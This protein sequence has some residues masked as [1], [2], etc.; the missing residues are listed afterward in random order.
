MATCPGCQAQLSAADVRAGQCTACGRALDDPGKQTD[1]HLFAATIQFD[2]GILPDDAD[3]ASAGSPPAAGSGSAAPIGPA[4]AT[5]AASESKVREML[6]AGAASVPSAPANPP[7]APPGPA[8]EEAGGGTV[9]ER[10]L[11]QTIDS[12]V[13][14]ADSDSTR[15]SDFS[16]GS[17]GGSGVISAGPGNDSQTLDSAVGGSNSFDLG[18]AGLGASSAEL[19]RKTASDR[20]RHLAQTFD[21]SVV[22]S[23][24]GPVLA[25]AWGQEVPQEGDGRMTIKGRA[26]RGSRADQ[27]LVVNARSLQPVD[28]P[29]RG[30]ADYELLEVLGEGGMGVV[31]AARQASIDRT[32]AV[33][34]LKPGLAR[35]RDLE[36]K[37]LSEAVVTGDLDH[38]NIVPMYDL[39]K[40]D[41]GALFYA[42]KRVQGTPWSKAIG[43]KSLH[44]NLEILMK[45]ADAVAFAHARGVVHRD[46]KPENVMLGEFGEVLV[47]DWGLAY[48]TPEFRKSGSITQTQSMGGSPAYMAPEMALGPLDRISPL[49]DVYLLGAILYEIITGKPPHRGQNVSKCLAAAARNEIQPTDKS[50]EL[51]EIALRAM[52]TEPAARY[53]TVLAFQQALRDYL[54]HA[55]SIVLTGRA[56]QDLA[57]AT[58]SQ[59]Y[60]TFARALFAFEEALALWEGNAR[61]RTSAA[62]ARLAY[63]TCAL[64]K[65]DY[66]LAAG[67]LTADDPAHAPLAAR[68]DEARRERDARQRRLRQAKRVVVALGVAVVVILAVA[69]FGIRS[70][71]DRALVAESQARDDRDRAVV[72]E[73]QAK[74]DRDRAV[75]AE[76]QAKQDRDRAIAAGEQAKEERDRAVAAEAVAERERDRAEEAHEAEEYQAYIARIGLASAKI[77]E[78]AFDGAA[79]L[80]DDCPPELRHWEWGRLNYLCGQSRLSLDAGAPASAVAW[81]PDG[82]RAA[83]AAWNGEVRV[84]QWPAGTL[85]RTIPFGGT[86]VHAVAWSPDGRQLA[87][88]GGDRAGPVKLFDA[89]SGRLLRKL[90]GHEDSVTSVRFSRDGKRLLTASFDGTARLW[91]AASGDELA[92]FRG[93]AWWVWSAAF[94]PDETWIVTASQDGTARVWSVAAQLRAETGSEATPERPRTFA[95]HRGPVFAVAIAADGRRVATAGDD[96]RVLVWNPADARPLRLDEVLADPPPPGPAFAELSGHRGAVYALDFAPDGKSLASGGRDN[97]VRLWDLSTG[98][99]RHALRGHSGQVRSVRFAPEGGLLLSAAQDA[100]LKLWDPAGYAEQRVVARHVLSGHTDAVLDACLTADGRRVVTAGRDRVARLWDLATGRE[101]RTFA[102][103]HTLLASTVLVSPDGARLVTAAGDGTA[104]VW[105]TAGATQIAAFEDTGPAAVAALSADGAFLAT[106]RSDN[107]ARVWNLTTGQIAAELPA[108]RTEVT[109]LAF[110]PGGG[111]LALGESS[112][113]VQLW[114]LAAG[115][116]VWS[117]LRHSRKITA[118]AWADEGRTLLSASLDNTVAA[119]DTAAGQE[120]TERVLKHPDGVTSLALVADGRV[121]TTAADGRARLWDRAAA[122]EVAAPR[123]AQVSGVSFAAASADGRTLALIEAAGA[124]VRVVPAAALAEPAPASDAPLGTVVRLIDAPPAWTA[125]L[126]ADGKQLFTVGAQEAR[127]WDVA[128]GRAVA[129]YSPHGVVA[130]VDVALDGRRLVTASWDRSVRVWDLETGRVLRKLPDLH[131]GFVNSARFSADGELLLTAGDDGLAR[132]VD[133]A[134]GQERVRFAGHTGRVLRAALSGDGRLVATA[135]A[136]KTA[137]LWDAATGRS[138]HVL[139]GHQWGVESAEFSPDGKLVVTASADDRA[140]VWDVATGRERVAL[141]GHTAG[142][143]SARFSGDGR[144]IVTASRDGTVKLWDAATGKELL[145]LTGHAQEVTSARFAPGDRGVLSTGREGTAVYWPASPWTPPAEAAEPRGK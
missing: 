136:D 132:L 101:V 9:H 64:E 126:S 70:Q 115:R 49:S 84:W 32:V 53:P 26:G 34:M 130:S 111:R 75:V 102:E 114:D 27:T 36:Q 66:D 76:A 16:L 85:E 45:V 92:V 143:S 62:Q 42:M 40:N 24:V 3:A 125:A 50:G 13:I 69:Y 144:R 118:L 89:A 124:Q 117:Q 17:G 5:V 91:D 8:G 142:L 21:S 31:Y 133:A 10:Q 14:G 109:A 73:G 135:S 58:T 22:G 23:D 4:D 134:T 90:V 127:R 103:G 107:R 121:V 112:G 52:A 145:T 33:K 54:A 1:P 38:P 20:D 6:A 93:H 74:Q 56:E 37:F 44:E 139:T 96:G 41:Q 87:A 68:I 128:S 116:A 119:W 99:E 11:A 138:L 29:A 51:V 39:G 47:M 59:S 113:R 80:L 28:A 88:G 43:K 67:L 18:R 110:A 82:A 7:V 123:L 131:R 25:K 140:L 48:S 78:N 2:S 30:A 81:S 19:G 55:E 60:E 83:S 94:G 79:A 72:A 97:A 104:C 122:R 86:Y 12:D 63:A 105:D 98:Q 77:D 108:Q 106:G 61:A 71:R 129:S 46:L 95:A 120:Q 65:G 57:A 100:T 141:A 35:N 137:R 15:T